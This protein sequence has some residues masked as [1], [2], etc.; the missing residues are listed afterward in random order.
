MVGLVGLDEG[1]LA[2]WETR[3]HG[4]VAHP[5]P[6]LRISPKR[7]RSGPLQ[8]QILRLL[9]LGPELQT[10]IQQANDEGSPRITERRL[11]QQVPLAS[12]KTDTL[13]TDSAVTNSDTTSL[14][15]QPR[16]S[17]ALRCPS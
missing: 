15:T 5:N 10:W 16:N 14:A 13:P 6:R 1:S 12:V 17:A 7:G 9:R 11:R 4:H 2:S 3:V 8:A